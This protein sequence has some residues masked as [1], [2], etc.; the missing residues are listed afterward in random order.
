VTSVQMINRYSH[1]RSMKRGLALSVYWEIEDLLKNIPPFGD[2][3]GKIRLNARLRW[4]V[5]NNQ[6]VFEFDPIYS[7]HVGVSLPWCPVHKLAAKMSMLILMVLNVFSAGGYPL[8]KGKVFLQAQAGA[9]INYQIKT[10]ISQIAKLPNAVNASIK[11]R[12]LWI[13]K[14]GLKV[15]IDY[16]VR[17]YHKP[18]K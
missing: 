8:A 6:L 12:D 10:L 14:D 16:K 2:C 18:D 7:Q 5:V 4:K 17:I 13:D 1:V 3:D 11:V 15:R 9:A